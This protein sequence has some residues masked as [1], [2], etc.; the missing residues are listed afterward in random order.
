MRT[1]GHDNIRDFYIGIVHAVQVAR[2]EL[3]CSMRDNKLGAKDDLSRGI[4][5]NSQGTA[6]Q[7]C[8]IQSE[9]W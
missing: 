8:R 5:L 4:A 7:S 1:L 6:L 2:E 9:W 3:V